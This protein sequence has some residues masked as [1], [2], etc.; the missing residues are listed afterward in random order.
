MELSI[1]EQT[2]F[3]VRILLA[4]RSGESIKGVVD[5]LNFE[6][7]IELNYI[8]INVRL[9][10]IIK[11]KCLEYGHP[12]LV[13][14]VIDIINKS[15]IKAKS[16]I[17]VKIQVTNFNDTKNNIFYIKDNKII[18]QKIH[19][20]ILTGQDEIYTGDQQVSNKFIVLLNNPS[21]AFQ[22][23]RFQKYIRDKYSKRK[24]TCFSIPLRKG[25]HY[26]G[27]NFDVSVY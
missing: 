4:I 18:K 11:R 16:E 14:I 24:S 21:I 5:I 6:Y 12:E 9:V 23:L 15:I 17:R 1:E 20:C 3:V 25:Y 19:E 27:N 2:L 26:S 13:K 22:Q 8:K 10:E 7:I